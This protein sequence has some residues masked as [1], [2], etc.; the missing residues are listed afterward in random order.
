MRSTI[1]A[2]LLASTAN[3][4]YFEWTALPAFPGTARDDASAFT[5]GDVVYVGTGRDVSF[6]LTRDWYSFEMQ[7][8]SWSPIADLPASGRQYCSS[9]S[10]GTYGY[11]FGGVDDAGPLNELWRYDPL[12][13]SWSAMT[14]L[15]APGRYATVSFNNGM[16]CTGLMSGGVATNECWQYDVASDSWAARAPVPGPPRHRAAGSG[17]HVFVIGGLSAEGDVLDDAHVYDPVFDSWSAISPIPGARFGADAVFD[18]ALGTIYIVAGASSVTEFHDEAW[19]GATWQPIADFAGGPRRGGVMAFG[20]PNMNAQNIYYGTGVDDTQRH[21]DWWV[22]QNLS[23]TVHEHAT[24][25]IRI[26]PNPSNGL[27]RM[28]HGGEARNMIYRL[29]DGTGRMIETGHYHAGDQ[30]DLRDLAPGR[31]IMEARENGRIHHGQLSII[32]AR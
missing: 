27:V 5:V 19:M 32:T 4:Q 31:Y 2:L 1:V 24:D 25:A 12:Q 8:G 10:D 15:P 20:A 17:G 7:S 9:F 16:V 21:S 11:L 3:A 22:Y 26:F 29:M 18:D 28:D 23:E 6:A 30:L 13:D 14:P